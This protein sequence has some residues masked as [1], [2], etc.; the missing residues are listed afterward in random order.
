MSGPLWR[1]VASKFVKYHYDLS[2]AQGMRDEWEFACDILKPWVESAH[3]ISVQLGTVMELA[4]GAAEEKLAT[5][6]ECVEELE[7]NL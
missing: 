2:N 3:V 6:E 1:T 7:G 5:L 4:L